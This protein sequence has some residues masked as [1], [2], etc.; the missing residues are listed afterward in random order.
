MRRRAVEPPPSIDHC[1]RTALPPENHTHINKPTNDARKCTCPHMH[2]HH[3]C[4]HTTIQT[5]RHT[6]IYT[7]P[8]RCT[9]AHT[10][11]P[12]GVEAVFAECGAPT[13]LSDPQEEGC[14][15]HSGHCGTPTLGITPAATFSMCMQAQFAHRFKVNTL[16]T[17]AILS[18][19]NSVRIRPSNPD[20]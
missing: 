2:A 7:H 18:K 13:P 19:K 12:L 3:T 9:H 17:K 11:T 15:I 10:H 6:H 20:F 16:E 4:I 1:S 5:R 14:S 8:H